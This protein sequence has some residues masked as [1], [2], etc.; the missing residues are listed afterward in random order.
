MTNRLCSIDGCTRT[1]KARGWCGT[2]YRRWERYGDPLHVEFEWT[3]KGTP[4]RHPECEEPR[5]GGGRGY[6]HLHYQRL[7]RGKNGLDGY[8]PRGTIQNGYRIFWVNGKRVPE[9]RLVMEK[10]IGRPLVPRVE[11]VHHKNGVRDDNR[12]EN[13]ELW[14]SM[15]PTGQRVSDLLAF[16][17]EVI[18]RYGN[19]SKAAL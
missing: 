6:C 15:Q 13:L 8:T 14:S 9:H 5:H 10:I 17:H 18:E 2:H 16:A 7:R 12:P 1:H 4:C 11:N 19:V 3:P